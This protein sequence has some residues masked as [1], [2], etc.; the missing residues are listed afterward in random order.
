MSLSRVHC[1][2]VNFLNLL[3]LLGQG[4]TSGI[5]SV[6]R[7]FLEVGITDLVPA[8]C[9]VAVDGTAGGIGGISLGWIERCCFLGG[10]DDGS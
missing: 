5:R 7:R 4:Q 9:D 3:P 1:L 6:Y 10:T 8:G 2:Q